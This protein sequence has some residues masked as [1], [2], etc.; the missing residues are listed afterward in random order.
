[1]AKSTG[2][3]VSIVSCRICGERPRVISGRHLS[4]HDTDRMTY[5]EEYQLGPDE[6]LAKAFRLIQSCRPGYKPRG[7]REWISAIRKIYKQ[8]GS[9]FARDLQRNRSSLYEQG[10]WL[11]GD[12]NNALKAAGFDPEKM[13]NLSFWD[14]TRITK[15]RSEFV[16]R[17][18]TNGENRAE[19]HGRHN[20]GSLNSSQR[21]P[22]PHDACGN[23]PRF[24]LLCN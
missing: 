10:V 9:I 19:R 21:L 16:L 2:L 23:A 1:M 15:Y 11:F 22:H 6:L 13:R 14:K 12:W 24:F 3:K 17:A 20:L 18:E 8:G 4:K 5:I 7:K